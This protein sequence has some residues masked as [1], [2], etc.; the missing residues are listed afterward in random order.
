MNTKSCCHGGEFFVSF[1]V[2]CALCDLAA[3]GEEATLTNQE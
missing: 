2:L 1:V 3:V